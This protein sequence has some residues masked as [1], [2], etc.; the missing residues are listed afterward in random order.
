MFSPTICR[1]L[2]S[3]QQARS[4]I[5]IGW[6]FRATPFLP[7]GD[8]QPQGTTTQ[9]RVILFYVFK[10]VSFVY[11]QVMG[12]FH[13]VQRVHHTVFSRSMFCGLF[14]GLLP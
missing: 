13:G 1:G 8:L 11:L 14:F 12:S 6:Q 7:D 4:T 10:Y 5:K 2:V 9:D 3:R